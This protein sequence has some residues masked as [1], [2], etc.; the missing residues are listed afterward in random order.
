MQ[1]KNNILIKKRG[2][3]HQKRD[4]MAMI[5]AIALIVILA[6]IMALALSMTN[7]TTKKTGDLYLHEQAILLSK[8]ATEYALLKIGKAPPCTIS[9]IDFTHNDVFDINI[10]LKYV[11]KGLS[12]SDEYFNISTDEQNGSVLIDVTVKTNDKAMVGEPI[13]YFRRSMNKL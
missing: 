3:N 10:S 8:S 11:Y 5:M 7:L 9:K 6:T 1:R 4:G 2:F 12:C 13:V